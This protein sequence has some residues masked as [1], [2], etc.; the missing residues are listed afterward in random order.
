MAPTVKIYPGTGFKVD[1]LYHIFE[2]LKILTC[3]GLNTMVL[4]L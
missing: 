2:G 4:G 3:L 1:L